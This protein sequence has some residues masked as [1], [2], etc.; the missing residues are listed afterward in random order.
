M[1]RKGGRGG[2]GWVHP[3]GEKSMAMSGLGS[4]KVLV[5]NRRAISILFGTMDLETSCLTLQGLPFQHSRP[6]FQL[7]QVSISSP[8]DL[9]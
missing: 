2:G 6:I 7:Y 1:T 4:R 9:V 5:G 8:R 3:Q